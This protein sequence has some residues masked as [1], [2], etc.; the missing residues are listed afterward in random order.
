VG[1]LKPGERC[2]VVADS[3]WPYST[4]WILDKCGTVVPSKSV[5]Y[6]GMIKMTVEKDEIFTVPKGYYYEI[7][8]SVNLKVIGTLKVEEGA[9]LK[10]Q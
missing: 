5:L 10:V 3:E 2:R 9:I 8:K 7:P 6:E 4:K 1:I